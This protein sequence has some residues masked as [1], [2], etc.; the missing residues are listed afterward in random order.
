M[1]ACNAER[2]R[3]RMER[4]RGKEYKDGTIDV[5]RDSKRS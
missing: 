2:E 3:G 4:V 5:K 1:F